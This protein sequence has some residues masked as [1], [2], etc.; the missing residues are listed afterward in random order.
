MK[1]NDCI[2]SEFMIAQT[3]VYWFNLSDVHISKPVWKFIVSWTT[4]VL[5]SSDDQG[6]GVAHKIKQPKNQPQ[7][8]PDV[9]GA[10]LVR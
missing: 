4:I 10:V 3:A 5:H 6:V 1:N 9:D 8:F 7:S 2:N